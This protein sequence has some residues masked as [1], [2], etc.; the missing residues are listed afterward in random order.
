MGPSLSPNSSPD[1]VVFLDR[2]GVINRDSPGYIKSL[3]EFEF[4]P[5]SLSALQKLAESHIK[6]IVITNQS[7]INRGLISKQTLDSIHTS[8]ITEVLARGGC[9]E[10]IFFCPH[11]PQEGCACRKPAPGMI[12][13]AR[14]KHGINLSVAGMVGD[15]A[16]DIACARRAQVRY[17]VLV[18]TGNFVQAQQELRDLNLRPD[19]VARDLY[20][21]V[22]W[23]VEQFQTS[24]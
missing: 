17:A 12:H 21:A 22:E 2:D 18:K 19:R 15:S 5:R 24:R 11:T 3:A 16:K 20:A 1:P 9:I 13:S 6:T 7:A 8:M 4:L 14:M 10:D 23:I